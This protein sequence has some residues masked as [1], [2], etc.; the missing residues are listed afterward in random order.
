[1]QVD[2]SCRD[3]VEIDPPINDKSEYCGYSSWGATPPTTTFG[4]D[5]LVTVRFVSDGGDDNWYTGFSAIFNIV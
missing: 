5:Q 2:A 1:M 3:Y 4:V